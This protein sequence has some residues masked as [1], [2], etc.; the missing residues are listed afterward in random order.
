MHVSCFFQA[1]FFLFRMT[2]FW[3]PAIWWGHS[4]SSDF[5]RW[6]QPHQPTLESPEIPHRWTRNAAGSGTHHF[7]KPSFCRGHLWKNRVILSKSP[8]LYDY[9]ISISY[10]IPISHHLKQPST[11][12]IVSL[13]AWRIDD[14][15]CFCF[16]IMSPLIKTWDLAAVF[17][18]QQLGLSENSVP[19]NPLL[20]HHFI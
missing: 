11:L 5:K 20:T 17:F 8:W 3:T 15:N 6:E 1:A 7:K 12:E 13:E 16:C 4:F 19:L 14:E 18:S 9:I 10:S 2:W